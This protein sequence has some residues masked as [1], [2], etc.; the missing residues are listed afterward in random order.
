[1]LKLEYINEFNGKIVPII[2]VKREKKN[3]MCRIKCALNIMP[4][5]R[6]SSKRKYLCFVDNV[7]SNY[8]CKII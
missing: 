2:K 7:I 8:R 4:S 3:L 6:S 1:M 5:W